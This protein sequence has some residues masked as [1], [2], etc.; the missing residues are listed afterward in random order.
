MKWKIDVL[1]Y[2][3]IVV[4]AN[5]VI[6]GLQG[7][8]E[9][10]TPYLGFLLQSGDHRILVD[11]GI[12][13]KSIINGMGWGGYPTRGGHDH[14]EN[15]LKMQG[16]APDD[17]EMLIYTHL[18]N[19]HAGACDLFPKATHLFQKD[20][21]LNLLDPIPAQKVRVD[22]DLSVIPILEKMQTLKINGDLEIF[23]GIKVYKAPGH[24]LGS[25]LITVDTEKG[26]MVIIGDLC[27]R[28]CH[29]FP[30]IDEIT[31]LTG[32]THKI[33]TN[34]E[35]YG[36]AVPTAAIYDYFAWYD[37]IAKAKALSCGKK[38]FVLPG[39]EPSLVTE[40]REIN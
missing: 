32:K 30:E 37:S 29:F 40:F 11:C 7:I 39:H 25:Q 10:E 2:G 9:M 21:W 38:E 13:E 4:P 24:S 22:Y 3:T 1:C 20:E 34:V 33:K 19:D 18:H 16:V 14:V 31:D 27:N 35:L 36:P 12:N 28:Y 5:V 15:S 17:I 6:P 23:S 8:S 26:M